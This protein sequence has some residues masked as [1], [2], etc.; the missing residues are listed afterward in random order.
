MPT[1]ET[2][3]DWLFIAVIV[4]IIAFVFFTPY[5][6]KDKKAVEGKADP[7]VARDWQPTGQINFVVPAGAEPTDK[8]AYVLEIEEDRILELLGGG[9]TKE[10]RYR[11]AT[12]ADAVGVV[13]A[14]RAFKGVDN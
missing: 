11:L 3:F 12:L 2:F 6:L 4:L 1:L 5:I 13:K 14:Y 7:T 8:L 9:R 10:V